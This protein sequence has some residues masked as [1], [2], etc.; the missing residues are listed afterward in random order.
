ML[1]KKFTEQLQF[2]QHN[3]GLSFGKIII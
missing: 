1:K 3:L 2:L